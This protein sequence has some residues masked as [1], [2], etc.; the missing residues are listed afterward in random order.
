ME[1]Y[2]WILIAVCVTQSAMFSGLNLAY[3]SLPKLRLEVELAKNNPQALIIANLRK[4]SNF[5]LA[6]IL[7]GNVGINVLLTILSDSVLAGVMGFFF[8]T[9]AITIFGEIMPQAYFSRNAMRMASL[10]TPLIRFYQI[11]LFPLAKPTAII[12]NRWLGK[13]AIEYVSEEDLIELIELQKNKESETKIAASESQGMLNIL[14]LKNIELADLGVTIDPESIVRMKSRDG[15]IVMPEIK[16]NQDDDFAKKVNASMKEWVILVDEQD[17]P[18]YV[19]NSNHYRSEY[20]KGKSFDSFDLFHNPL[21]FKSGRTSFME[22]LTSLRSK[23]SKVILVW[24]KE[25]KR[26]ITNR[27]ALR[28]VLKDIIID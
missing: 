12:L 21:T 20:S 4:D 28:L 15:K 27:E 16:A 7:W 26:I 11:L 3:F 10:L 9:F 8:S 5:L 1:V 14:N 23:P 19:L 22:A 25:E 6:T 17:E 13:E 18:Q 24:E 2:I